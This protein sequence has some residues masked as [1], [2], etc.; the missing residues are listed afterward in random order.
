MLVVAT[1]SC[2]EILDAEAAEPAET[3]ASLEHLE[4]VGWPAAADVRAW[5]EQSRTLRVL[6]VSALIPAQ[7]VP[8][9]AGIQSIE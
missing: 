9:F 6:R 8:E 7:V 1:S 2:E 4:D 5:C 3:Q